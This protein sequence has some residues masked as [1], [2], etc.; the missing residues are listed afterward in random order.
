MKKA[1]VAS[2]L[3][4]DN[5]QNS[6]SKK[7]IEVKDRRVEVRVIVDSGAAGLVMPEGL[8]PRVEFERKTPPKKFAAANGERLKDLCDKDFHSKHI[9]RCTTFRSTSVVKPL[10]AMQKV[11]P[12]GTIVVLDEKNSHVRNNRDGTMIKLDVNKGSVHN[13]HVDL[14][15]TGV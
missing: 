11:A 5:S 2:L 12:A 1:K 6:S 9:Q 3:S 10:I 4:V 13:G 14:L 8:F 15:P 7:I